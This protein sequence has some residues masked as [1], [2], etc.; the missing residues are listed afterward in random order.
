MYRPAKA[1]WCRHCGGLHPR[2]LG[3]GLHALPYPC[4]VVKVASEPTARYRLA[5]PVVIQMTRPEAS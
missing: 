5:T 3:N 4:P 1:K 2:S